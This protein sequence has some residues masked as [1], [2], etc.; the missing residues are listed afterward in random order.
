M[1]KTAFDLDHDAF[2][3]RHYIIVRKAE[4]LIA[5]LG[6]PIITCGVIGLAHVVRVS[7]EFDHQL[8]FTAKKVCKIGAN[9][10]LS[11]EFPSTDFSP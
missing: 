2:D 5:V 7:I 10:H 4:N 6:K 9:R 3:V 1:S 8:R 11:A